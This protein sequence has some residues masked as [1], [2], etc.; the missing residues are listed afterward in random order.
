[1]YGRFQRRN[2]YNWQ[3][4][5]QGSRNGYDERRRD[6]LRNTVLGKRKRQEEANTEKKKPI[7]TD[8]MDGKG[9]NDNKK[10]TDRRVF[11]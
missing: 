8:W 4:F 6:D 10:R 3:R 5:G 7:L 2:E 1:M 9:H 11:W